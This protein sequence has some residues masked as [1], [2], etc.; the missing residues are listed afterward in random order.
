MFLKDGD[1]LQAVDT[2]TELWTGKPPAERCPAIKK[3]KIPN[4]SIFAPGAVFSAD[5][6]A[7]DPQG[8][9]LQVKWVIQPEQT[10]K[11]TAGAEE[12]ALP[13]LTD[14]IVRGDTRLAE[15]RAPQQPGNYRLFAYVRNGV[16]AAV[17]NVPFQVAPGSKTLASRQSP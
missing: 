11:L 16:G 13:E 1:K 6:D 17:A 9:P 7:S 3:L 4:P 14:L 10:N 2:M 15:V 5:L 12:Q 8:R